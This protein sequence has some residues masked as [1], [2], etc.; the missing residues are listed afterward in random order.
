VRREWTL[1]E[2]RRERVERYT[3][4]VELRR[5]SEQRRGKKIKG[6]RGR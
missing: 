1:E 2:K 6:I 3:R 5:K 4:R